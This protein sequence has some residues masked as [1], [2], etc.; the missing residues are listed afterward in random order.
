MFG[1]LIIIYE[2]WVEFVELYEKCYQ[3]TEAREAVEGGY[4][5]YFIPLSH[6]EGTEVTIDGR[7]LSL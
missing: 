6:T 4:Y 1:P 2:R 7:K 3:F 5:P